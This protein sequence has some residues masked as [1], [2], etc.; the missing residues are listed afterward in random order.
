M[1]E[2]CNLIKEMD[3][4]YEALGDN[5]GLKYPIFTKY[6]K[7]VL[8]PEACARSGKY[9]ENK[10]LQKLLDEE[11]KISDKWGF[12]SDEEN[13]IGKSVWVSLISLVSTIS[14]SLK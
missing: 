12:K 5:P 13:K 3:E 9:P 1:V 10:K 8:K 2:S 6:R 4:K 11:H 14:L 7:Y